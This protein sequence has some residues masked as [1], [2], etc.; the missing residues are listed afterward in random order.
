MA[1]WKP[2]I[3]R[4]VSV[5]Y[6]GNSRWS[7]QRRGQSKINVMAFDCDSVSSSIILL[8]LLCWLFIS[9]WLL[10]NNVYTLRGGSRILS[11]GFPELSIQFRAYCNSLRT[12]ILVL[13]QSHH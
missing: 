10:H 1:E 2:S 7:P 12:L 3:L 9:C 5:V 8:H 13:C 11:E 4:A 6:F